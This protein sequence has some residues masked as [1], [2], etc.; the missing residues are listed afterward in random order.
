[1]ACGSNPSKLRAKRSQ[2]R[3]GNEYLGAYDCK[4]AIGLCMLDGFTPYANS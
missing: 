1:V 4:F 2:G 3:M